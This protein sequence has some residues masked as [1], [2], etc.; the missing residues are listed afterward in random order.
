MDEDY[1]Q[2]FGGIGRLFGASALPRLA[3][4]RVCVIGVGGVGS[5]IVEAL[6]RSGIGAITLVDMDDVCVTNTNRQLPA[7]QDTIGRPKVDVLADRVRAIH[8]RAEVR[9]VCEFLTGES[10]ERLI[11][12]GFDFVVDAVDRMSI[13]ALIIARCRDLGTP[14]ITLGSAGGRRDPAMIRLTDLGLAGKDELLQ[15]TRRKLRRD[16]GFPKSTDGRA[17]P[18]GVPCVLSAEPPVFP[19]DDGTCAPEPEP[20]AGPGVR[21]DCAAGYGAATFVT[22]AFGFAAAA[23]VVRRIAEA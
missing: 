19:W 17:L 15:Q 8:P 11:T 21:L 18:M 2:R 7:L 3:A 9:A 12:P 14:V 16:H 6:A 20:G 5:W 22:G 23:E 13:K 4:A 1:L 10:C